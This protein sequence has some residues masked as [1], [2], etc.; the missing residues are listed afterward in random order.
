MVSALKWVEDDRPDRSGQPRGFRLGMNSQK[1][2]T[3]RLIWGFQSDTIDKRSEV[4]GNV[5]VFKYSTNDTI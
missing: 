3:S 1:K 4:N 2:C 5:Q